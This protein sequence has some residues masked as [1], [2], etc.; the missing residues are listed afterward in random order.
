MNIRIVKINGN[1][2]ILRKIFNY[3]SGARAAAGM[4][5]KGWFLSFTANSFKDCIKLFL[6]IYFLFHSI[7]PSLILIFIHKQQTLVCDFMRKIF[8]TPFFA[9]CR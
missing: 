8:G 1:V 6:I 5:Q 4:Q 2:K 7:C 3:I 9:R